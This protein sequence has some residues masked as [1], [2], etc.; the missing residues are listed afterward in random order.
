MMRH[1]ALRATHRGQA[2]RF[3]L[4]RILKWTKLEICWLS[5]MSEGLSEVE[6]SQVSDALASVLGFGPGECLMSVQLQVALLRAHLL[7]SHLLPVSALCVGARVLLYGLK[8]LP[9]LNG[10]LGE[11][12]EMPTPGGSSRVAVYIVHHQEQMTGTR[13][14]LEPSH[15]QPV[16]LQR[17]LQSLP[18]DAP[19]IAHRLGGSESTVRL[20]SQNVLQLVT[21]FNW[22]VVPSTALLP[23]ELE[24]MILS[25]LCAATLAAISRACARYRR[26]APAV[27]AARL[28]LSPGT[29]TVI[30][31]PLRRLHAREQLE[32]R[33]GPRPAH[34]WS[35]EWAALICDN[36]QSVEIGPNSLV[37]GTPIE[38][39]AGALTPAISWLEA[40]GWP[41]AAAMPCVLLGFCGRAALSRTLRTCD[42]SYA[43]CN[44]LLCDRFLEQAARHVAEAEPPAPPAYRNLSGKV[45]QRTR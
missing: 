27:A 29:S 38:A 20:A 21:R 4:L 22:L 11:V 45:R 13:V 31:N 40:A 23:E 25:H 32:A 2:G 6:L 35:A 30:G 28:G 37:P 41:T 15:L 42:P 39:V 14:T 1:T 18:A 5:Q 16:L 24:R 43:A 8:E 12:V 17:S 19:P 44:H 9:E 33:I 34:E 10:T 7:P 36:A 3:Q 26:L